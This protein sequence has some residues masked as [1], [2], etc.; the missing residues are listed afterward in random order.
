MKRQAGYIYARAGWWVLR[1]RDAVLENGVIVRKQL[2]KQLAPI[3]P[4]HAR[5]K[6]PPKNVESM[7]EDFLRPMNSGQTNPQS[8]QTIGQFVESYFFPR[9]QNEIREC[10]LAGYKGRWRSQ[11]K[12]RCGDETLR[13]F[14]VLKAQGVIDNIHRQNPE[15]TRGTLVHLRNLL[16]LVFDDALRLELL[17][18]SKG[19][20]VRLVRIPKRAPK[21]KDTYAY[22]LRELE[23]MLAILPEPAATVCAVAGYAGL[24][25]SELRGLRWEDFDGQ[26]IMINRSVW[27]GFTN[28]PKTQ[29]SKAA[30]PVIPRLRTILEAHRM[31]CGSPKTG[32]MFANGAGK[33]ENLNNTLNRAILPALNRCKVCR[34][35]KAEHIAAQVSHEYLRDDNLPTWHGF[36]AF[37]RGLATT[38]YELRVDDLMIQKILRQEDVQTTRRH[39]IKTLPEQSIQAMAKLEAALPELCADRALVAMPTANKLPA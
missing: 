17:D 7:A 33:P 11:L 10:T 20:P 36:H 9:L 30:V 25:R 28:E 2:A 24:R 8:T 27:E 39:Y 15:M 29:G 3:A 34:K 38:L 21:G 31:A 13:D 23:T 5:L 32:P 6:R 19:N 12:P 4:E 35:P 18:K 37:R 26:R 16:S 14:N 22:T 1:Y